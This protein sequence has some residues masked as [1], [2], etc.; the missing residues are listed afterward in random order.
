MAIITDATAMKS[1]SAVACIKM[2]YRLFAGNFKKL[3]RGSWL[4][5]ALFGVAYAA[6]GVTTTFRLPAIVT[7]INL[8]PAL[9]ATVGREYLALLSLCLLLV[10]AGGLFEVLFYS[11]ALG[12][13]RQHLATGNMERPKSP[14]LTLD[15]HVAWRTLKAAL[16]SLLVVAAV[17]ALLVAIYIIGVKTS[18]I[19]TDSYV[20]N[21]AFAVMTIIVL[22]IV[23]VPLCFSPMKY[24]LN[25]GLHFWPLFLRDYTTAM[26]HFGQIFVVALV[27]A[28]VSAVIT[29]VLQLPATVIS[30]ANYYAN[31]GA[32]YGD[33]LGL[34]SYMVSLTAVVFFVAGAM[35][36]YIRL[37]AFFPLYYMYGSIETQ[38]REKQQYE[39]T[40]K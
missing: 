19:R 38:E 16:A 21:I 32:Y 7:Q 34:P 5:A 28:V 13:L 24:V 37:S 9:A 31:L 3:F 27:V 33:P 6:L 11:T 29:F 26:R 35:Q 36:A 25:D 2:G 14:W 1:N 12:S 17:M 10:V 15:K 23:G 18:L 30:A 40:T 20:G 4:L 39:L 8:N 22:L